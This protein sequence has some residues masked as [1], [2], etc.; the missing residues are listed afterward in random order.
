MNAIEILDD[1]TVIADCHVVGRL[2]PSQ[3]FDMA[4]QLV[5]LGMRRI[6][7]EEGASAI[8]PYTLHHSMPPASR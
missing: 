1:L 4:E 6:M 3:A 2:E 7:A 8:D 5:R